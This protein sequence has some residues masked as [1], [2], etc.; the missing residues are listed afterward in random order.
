[1][2]ES[3]ATSFATSYKKI[4]CLQQLM[5]TIKFLYYGTVAVLGLGWQV[6]ELL[7]EFRNFFA[8]LFSITILKGDQGTLYNGQLLKL[9]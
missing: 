3:I 9:S 7:F 1:L 8:V 6:P 4:G 5:L 2:T